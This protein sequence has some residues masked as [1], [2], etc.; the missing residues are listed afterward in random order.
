MSN[1]A[2]KCDE[3]MPSEPGFY[4]LEDIQRTSPMTHEELLKREADIRR[5]IEEQVR[6]EIRREMEEKMRVEQET[7]QLKTLQDTFVS[8]FEKAFPCY[9][10]LH[11]S[12]KLLPSI[13]AFYDNLLHSGHIILCIWTLY[14]S[15]QSRN[16]E[17]YM[18]ITNKGVYA[19]H[20]N[21]I[22]ESATDYFISHI[23][24]FNEPLNYKYTR[25]IANALLEPT[26]QPQ[27]DIHIMSDLS[28]PTHFELLIRLIPGS[29][30]N[31]S[32]KQL[33][34]FFE[35]YFNEETLEIFRFPPPM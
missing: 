2:T 3:E 20:P 21:K 33:G 12:G 8:R 6:S 31:G 7:Q 13:K 1:N 28:Y 19:F 34:G 5:E 25:L 35:P 18:M 9:H 32:W 24:S 30:S 27:S 17:M 15:Y 29:Y 26:R 22:F 11:S 10:C 16:I 14:Y 23:Y 4:R